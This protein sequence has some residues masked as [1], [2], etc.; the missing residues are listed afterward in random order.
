MFTA[1]V[2]TLQ[3]VHDVFAV[4]KAKTYNAKEAWLDQAKVKIKDLELSDNRRIIK[5]IIAYV[6]VF[7]H[8]TKHN[9]I[10]DTFA[11]CFTKSALQHLRVPYPP[12]IPRTQQD[13]SKRNEELLQS[14]FT[15]HFKEH[16]DISQILIDTYTVAPF[17][18]DSIISFQAA[19]SDFF[20]DYGRGASLVIQREGQPYHPLALTKDRLIMTVLFSLGHS[21]LV[22][23]VAKRFLKYF[24]N[25]LST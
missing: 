25:N 13:A 10:P 5:A 19:L 23:K 14:L 24:G 6:K 21:P 18:T 3:R 16:V 22:F 20:E 1:D 4:E 17:P 8:A 9:I 2:T 11:M 12:E 7:R 15:L